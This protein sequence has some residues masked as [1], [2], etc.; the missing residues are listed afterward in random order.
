MS[1][2]RTI[3][4]TLGLLACVVTTTGCGSNAGAGTADSVSRSSTDL[5]LADCSGSFRRQAT[6]FVPDMVTIAQDSAQQQR[7][8]WAGCFDGAP[9]R[10]LRWSIKV[11]FASVPPELA[12]SAE[13]V[14]RV[15]AAR[16]TGLGRRFKKMITTTPTRVAGSGLL[17]AL[18][19]ASQTPN[20]GRVFLFTDAQSNEVDGLR[21][22]TA[23][24]AQLR[25]TVRRWRARLGGGLDGVT[26]AMIGV[27]LDTGTSKAVRNAE[28][29]FGELITEAGGSLSWSQALSA[30]LLAT[31]SEEG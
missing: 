8:L 25:A 11:D 31:D 2:R 17:E 15:N 4:T 24:P 1:Q 19:L 5:V 20:V 21:L 13:V 3:T 23:S 6:S 22:A 7:T 30:D 27:G 16:A 29:L 28:Q 9:L 26:V 12:T 18:E 14:E 10:T